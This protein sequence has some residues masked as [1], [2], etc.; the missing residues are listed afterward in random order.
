MKR[1]QV[2]ALTLLLCVTF[3]AHA[4]ITEPK[5]NSAKYSQC[6]KKSEGI[7]VNMLDCIAEEDRYQTKRLDSN[8]KKLS[9]LLSSAEK[10]KLN[11]AQKD[12]QKYTQTTCDF[13]HT[14]ASG[15]MASLIAN[16]CFL[17]NTT[18]RANLLGYWLDLVKQAQE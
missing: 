1:I 16:N 14:A 11:N 18:E 5:N 15:T 2:T 9:L 8:L 4:Q 17:N 10:T 6:M 12:W 13:Y 7:T 3:T